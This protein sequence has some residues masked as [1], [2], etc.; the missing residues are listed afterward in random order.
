MSLLTA[1]Q[2]AELNRAILHYLRAVGATDAAAA[3]ATHLGDDDASGGGAG[4]KEKY[5]GLLEKKWTSVVR[6]QRKVPDT[7][8]A[9]L[10]ID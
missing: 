10:D 2:S 7:I 5:D 4:D 1:K 3:M 9:C 6:L 8:H